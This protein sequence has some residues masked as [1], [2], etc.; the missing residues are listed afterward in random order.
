MPARIEVVRF[1]DFSGGLQKDKDAARLELNESPESLNCE[2]TRTGAVRRRKGVTKWSINENASMSMIDYLFHWQQIGVSNDWFVAID[3]DGDI[4]YSNTNDFSGAAVADYA[5]ST[6]SR[7]EFKAF[8]V[9]NDVLY[10]SS[11][12]TTLPPYK[13]DGTNWTAI[14]DQTLNGSGNEFPRA[15]FLLSK[16]ERIFAFSINNANFSRVWWSDPGNAE[17]WQSTSW[18]DVD[19]DDGSEIQG[20]SHFADSILIFKDRSI[21]MLSGT[22]ENSFTLYPVDQSVGTV[23]PKTIA[24]GAN[25]VFWLDPFQGVYTFDGA[26]VE[27]ISDPIK[28]YLLDNIVTSDPTVVRH[29]AFFYNDKYYLS[30]C[31]KSANDTSTPTRTFVYDTRLGAWTEWSIGFASAVVVDGVAYVGRPRADHMGGAATVGIYQW[32]SGTSD[33]GVDFTSTFKTAWFSPSGSVNNRHRIRHLVLFLTADA[34]SGLHQFSLFKDFD[35]TDVVSS[36]AIN[37]TS[38]LDEVVVEM[39]GVANSLARAYQL[40]IVETNPE[41][42]QLNG[43]EITYNVRPYKRGDLS[44]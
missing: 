11:L 14:N 23:C 7:R 33:D 20:V 25:K 13:F 12:D 4:Y 30:V 28:E 9:L 1:A 24:S 31:W 6:P 21:F 29:S 27:P 16:H 26:N 38:S 19:P 44:A 39:Q 37:T 34:S 40:E 32:E 10:L 8:A 18:I 43:I 2:F 36:Q 15:R 22:D 3:N 41:P 35:N 42:W 17:T 5:D